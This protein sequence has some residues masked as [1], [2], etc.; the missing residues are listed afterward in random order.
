MTNACSQRL[1]NSS[2]PMKGRLKF[3]LEVYKQGKSGQL[4]PNKNQE[5]I[6]LIARRDRARENLVAMTS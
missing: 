3:H 4:S 6:D 5:L 1:M 2:L